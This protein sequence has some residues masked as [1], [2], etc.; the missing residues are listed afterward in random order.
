MR[1]LPIR[2]LAVA[3]VL[4]LLLVGLVFAENRARDAGREVKL[5]MEAVDPRNL[6][7]GHYIDL[8]LTQRLPVDRPCPANLPNQDKPG[9][10]ALKAIGDRH[11]LTGGAATREAAQKQGEIVV[12]GYAW[13]RRVPGGAD[14]QEQDAVTL[15]IGVDRFHAAQAD[16]ERMERDLRAQRPGDP[17]Q[18]FAIVSVGKEG[19]ARLKAVI[20]GGKRSDLDWW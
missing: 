8:D 18:A 11:V 6:L 14:G 13:C 5:S 12:R 16:A 10:L 3:G 9:W 15:E 19:R 17:A 4:A 7:T 2:I 20:L 1:S